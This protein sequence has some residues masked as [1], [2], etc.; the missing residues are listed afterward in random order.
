MFFSNKA[1]AGW[2]PSFIYLLVFHIKIPLKRERETC[3]RELGFAQ[4]PG[5]LK[6]YNLGDTKAK[7]MRPAERDHVGDPPS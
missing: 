6:N 3:Q 4:R 2:K 7:E 5:N 1:Q